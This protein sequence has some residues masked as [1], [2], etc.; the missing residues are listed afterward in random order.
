MKLV[1]HEYPQNTAHL[2]FAG[3][4]WDVLFLKISLQQKPSNNQ[5]SLCVLRTLDGL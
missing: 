3:F 5:T 1:M 2:H 4:F